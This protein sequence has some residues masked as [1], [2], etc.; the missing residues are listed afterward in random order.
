M[1]SRHFPGVYEILVKKKGIQAPL[2][3]GIG[4]TAFTATGSKFIFKD[5]EYMVIDRSG[6]PPTGCLVVK[7]V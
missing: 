2:S 6:L 3:I 1:N 7:E 4:Y 5:K